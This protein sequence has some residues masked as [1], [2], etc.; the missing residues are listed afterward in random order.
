MCDALPTVKPGDKKEE[1]NEITSNVPSKITKKILPL[2]ALVQQTEA[3]KK[4]EHPIV[5]TIGSFDGNGLHTGHLRYLYAALKS[6]GDEARL[7]VGVD[8]DEVI[9]KYKKAPGRPFTNEANRCE[10]VAFVDGVSFVTLIHDVDEQGRW[11]YELLKAVKPDI[12][13]AEETSYTEEQK[14]DIAQYCG[15]LIILKRQDSSVSTTQYLAKI[16]QA[17][18]ANKDTKGGDDDATN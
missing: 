12:F 10:I 17:E 18:E 14:K 6:G 9:K 2:W 4:L 8:S 15:K 3:L 13:I 7:V 11:L 1:K 5:I 16:K